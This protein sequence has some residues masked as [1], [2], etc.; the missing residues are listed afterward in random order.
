MKLGLPEAKKIFKAKTRHK[1]IQ[2]NSKKFLNQ[3][4]SSK[5]KKAKSQKISKKSKK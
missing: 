1:K 3:K 2:I 5:L 4:K